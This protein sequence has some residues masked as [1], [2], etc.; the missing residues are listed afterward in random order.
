MITN[1]L[2]NENDKKS[3]DNFIVDEHNDD[4][5]WARIR[6]T[7]AI[8]HCVAL[9]IRM[10]WWQWKIRE[11]RN[12]WLKITIQRKR[13]DYD[14]NFHINILPLKRSQTLTF[15]S[16]KTN[17]TKYTSKILSHIHTSCFNSQWVNDQWTFPLKFTQQRQKRKSHTWSRFSVKRTLN[18]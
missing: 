6:T 12:E 5:D 3:E 15:V 1:Y 7:N 11:L 16:L 18:C 8:I 13:L 9:K 4:F 14:H 10:P 2:A 17:I